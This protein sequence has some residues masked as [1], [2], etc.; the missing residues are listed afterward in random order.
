MEKERKTNTIRHINK[1]LS[2]MSSSVDVKA[3]NENDTMLMKKNCKLPINVCIFIFLAFSYD[4][5]FYGIFC[6]YHSGL[7]SYL[8]ETHHITLLKFK[9]L[10][11]RLYKC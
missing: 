9:Q 11:F 3:N 2:S 5:A 4:I 8:R 6:I 7:F 10:I 1:C